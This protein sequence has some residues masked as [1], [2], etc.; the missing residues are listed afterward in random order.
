MSL[1]EFWANESVGILGKCVCGNFGQM[2]LWEFGA[3]ESVGIWGKRVCGNFGQLCLWEFRANESLDILELL[4]KQVYCIGIGIQLFRNLFLQMSLA[5]EYVVVRSG[6]CTRS[7][8]EFNNVYYAT[9]V[10]QP[11]GRVYEQLF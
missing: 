7:N 10:L 8:Y 1:W 5:K 6:V 4:C 3:N 9:R 11:F 2:S